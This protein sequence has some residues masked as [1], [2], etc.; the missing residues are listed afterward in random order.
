MTLKKSVRKS[1]NVS[2][3]N[4]RIRIIDDILYDTGKTH[5]PDVPLRRRHFIHALIDLFQDGT[6]PADLLIDKALYNA[7]HEF[8][9]SRPAIKSRK[10][11]P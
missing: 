2:I 3:R 10:K 6:I 4:E 8:I 11:Y 7:D 1:Q 5:R 9:S